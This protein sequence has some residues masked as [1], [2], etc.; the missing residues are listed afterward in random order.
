[1]R[2]EILKQL[3]AEYK[4]GNCT[5]ELVAAYWQERFNDDGGKVGLHIEVPPCDWTEEEI[6]RPMVDIWGEKIPGLMLPDL[7]EITLPL[8]SRIYP[9]LGLGKMH[10]VFRDRTVAEDSR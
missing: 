5:P 1:M 4:R 2:L 7:D 10:S 9:R 3:I 8:L 6:R